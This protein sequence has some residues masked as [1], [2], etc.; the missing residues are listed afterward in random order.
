MKLGF[1]TSYDAKTVEFAHGVGFRSMEL[2]AWPD[3]S[4]NAD[5]V[6]SHRIA[7]V[8]KDLEAHDIE[9]SALGYYPN[10]LDPDKD[11]AEEASRY[12]Y[13][14]L[15]LAS[16]MD[17]PVVCTFA[18]RDPDRS[19]S[20]NIPLFQ[21][22][23]TPICEEAESRNLLIA[24]E[25]CPMMDRF[26]LR[27][28]NIAISPEVWDE[29]FRAVPSEALGIELDPSHMVWQGIDYIQAIH[30]YGHRIHHIHAKDMEINRRTLGRVGILGQAFG[31]ITGLGHGWWRARLPGWGEIN[32]P[33]FI[34]GLIEAGY[35]GNID[36]EHEDDVFAAAHARE[37]IDTESG[38]V[39]KYGREEKGLILGYNTLSKLIPPED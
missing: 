1:Y 3:S 28:E 21:K 31:E 26:R 2:S 17:V 8:K 10:P 15:E 38:I 33:G 29:M 18:G 19:I 37:H 32:W 35:K 6:T 20:E 23:F 30:E 16:R 7:E 22:A 36:I 27:G 39:E 5:T 24:V 4:L 25:N 13:K 12:L 11:K 34:T 9:I 14:V